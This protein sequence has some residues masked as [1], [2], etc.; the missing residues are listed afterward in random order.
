MTLAAN[1]AYDAISRAIAATPGKI[2]AAVNRTVIN[3]ARGI[4]KMGPMEQRARLLSLLG[5][6]QDCVFPDLF[7]KLQNAI[8]AESQRGRA[9]HWAFDGNRLIALR[10]HLLARQ[11]ERRFER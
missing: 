9:G 11:Y 5:L 6:H 2:N 1:R 3:E 8:N 7:A 4:L 10:G